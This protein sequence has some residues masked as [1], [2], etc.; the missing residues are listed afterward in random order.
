MDQFLII[1]MLIQHNV[2]VLK[3]MYIL[4]MP[5][6]SKKHAPELENPSQSYLLTSS[7]GIGVDCFWMC[8]F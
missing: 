2:T 7:S 6:T 4:E 8:G 1:S 3:K 5:I